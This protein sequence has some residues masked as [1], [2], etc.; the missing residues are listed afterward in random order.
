MAKIG[1]ARV[2]TEDQEL[3]YQIKALKDA[4]CDEIIQGK[5]SGKAETNKEQ[6]D[7]LL[8]RVTKGDIVIVTKLDRLGRSLLQILNTIFELERIG[9]GLQ[10]LDGAISTIDRNSLFDKAQ[11]VLFGLL[12]E[13][14]RTLIVERTKQGRKDSGNYGGRPKAFSESKLKKLYSDIDNG[15]SLN[16][17]C[18]IHKKGRTTIQRYRAEYL[19]SKGQSVK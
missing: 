18:I 3:K 11:I 16:Q 15:M 5:H 14:E 19:K 2:S 13:I 9:V 1:Y 8:S 12:A 10:T 17:L 4:G 7:K 6:I